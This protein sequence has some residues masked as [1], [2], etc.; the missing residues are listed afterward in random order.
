MELQSVFSEAFAPYG[1][2]V[3]GVNVSELRETLRRE[4]EKPEAGTLYEPSV[5]AL[6]K[7]PVFGILQN[8]VYGGQPIQIGCCNGTN[9][10][11]NCLEYHRSSEI[12]IPDDDMVFLLARQQEIKGGKLSTGRVEAF[13]APAGAVVELYAT[14]LH[15]AP[16]D[17]ARGKGFRVAVVL[18]RGT[19]TEK[20]AQMAGGGEEDRR[21]WANNKWLLAHPDSAEA[22]QGAYVGLT[23]ENLD[24]ASDL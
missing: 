12:N 13:R 18:P 11:L 9:T 1:R 5:A 4:T 7:L 15:Y 21:L 23:G 19:N 14:T 16:C 17:G 2:V 10:K 8:S 24:I 20:P 3:S 6:E 22:G